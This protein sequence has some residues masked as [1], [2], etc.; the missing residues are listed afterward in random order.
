MRFLAR[1]E[2]GRLD[3]RGQLRHCGIL[4]EIVSRVQDIA[5]CRREMANMT[6]LLKR[7]LA[8]MMRWIKDGLRQM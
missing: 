8:K 1:M 4:L 5:D 3:S 6:D 7:S 2:S